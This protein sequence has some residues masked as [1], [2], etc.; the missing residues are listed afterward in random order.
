MDKNV[1]WINIDNLAKYIKPVE[2][3]YQLTQISIIKTVPILAFGVQVSPTHVFRSQMFHTVKIKKNDVFDFTSFFLPGFFS[4]F[5][6]PTVSCFHKST[7]CLHYFCL[8]FS[9]CS[10]GRCLPRGSN[11][12]PLCPN[13]QD[14][15]IYVEKNNQCPEMKCAASDCDKCQQLSLTGL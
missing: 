14:G 5:W 2:N 10:R 11:C 15:S 3:V 8:C 4:I 9:G 7:I 6:R 12:E 1:N 13:S